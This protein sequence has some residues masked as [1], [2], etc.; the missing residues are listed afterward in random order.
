M[1]FKLQCQIIEPSAQ[2]IFQDLIDFMRAATDLNQRNHIFFQ[3]KLLKE[4]LYILKRL[5]DEKL[6]EVKLIPTKQNNK[7]KQQLERAI[8]T[9]L[10]EIIEL[11]WSHQM[12][13]S[14]YRSQ[15]DQMCIFSQQK[16][17]YLFRIYKAKRENIN[18]A[19]QQRVCVFI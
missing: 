18:S 12:T 16:Y 9:F 15:T 11:N 7:E 2:V 10:N 4:D 1:A 17:S 3:I 13:S 6:N 8:Q 19:Q 14:I 5:I